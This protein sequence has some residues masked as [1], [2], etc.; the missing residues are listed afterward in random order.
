MKVP[1]RK[2]IISNE[3]SETQP[4]IDAVMAQ[5]AERKVKNTLKPGPLK[6]DRTKI[7]VGN[8]MT[9]L[10]K[11]ALINALRIKGS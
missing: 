9:L 11:I 4:P 7:I 5:M 6:K 10:T 2:I 8:E 1:G 3:I